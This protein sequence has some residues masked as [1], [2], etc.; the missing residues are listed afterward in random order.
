MPFGEAMS[1][2]RRRSREHARTVSA[3][4][5]GERRSAVQRRGKSQKG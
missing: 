3:Q 4:S 2:E 1:M 5:I